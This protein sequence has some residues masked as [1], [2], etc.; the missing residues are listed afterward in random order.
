[1]IRLGIMGSAM[2]VNLVR[3]GSLTP[4][5]REILR[6]PLPKVCDGVTPFVDRQQKQ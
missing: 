2:A 5:I 1:M 3:G 4:L 6:L